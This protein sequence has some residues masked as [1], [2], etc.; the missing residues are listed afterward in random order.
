MFI[1]YYLQYVE[2]YLQHG[3]VNVSSIKVF[4]TTFVFVS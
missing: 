3:T 2:Y 1:E 4:H